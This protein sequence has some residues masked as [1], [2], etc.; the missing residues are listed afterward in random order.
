MGLAAALATI[1]PEEV[2]WAVIGSLVTVI[3]VVTIIA[4]VSCLRAEKRGAEVEL[5][6]KIPSIAA[7]RWKIRRPRDRPDS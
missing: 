2:F 6:F 7:I 3:I 1:N 4:A 5:E